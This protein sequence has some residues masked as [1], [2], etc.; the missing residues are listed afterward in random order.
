[1][2]EP[3]CV[4]QRIVLVAPPCLV[5]IQAPLHEPLDSAEVPV[6]VRHPPVCVCV[7]ACINKHVRVFVSCM[8][9]S[10]DVVHH[11]AKRVC[12]GLYECVW[13]CLCMCVSVVRLSV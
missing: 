9:V 4:V 6:L 10:A 13:A 8:D 7:R 3:C 5:D 2:P 1:M 12:C 11:I